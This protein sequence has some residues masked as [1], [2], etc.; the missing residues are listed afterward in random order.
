[1]KAGHAI[2]EIRRFGAAV[3]VTAADPDSL[4]EVS[5]QAPATAG[6]AALHQLALMKL[7]RAIE[8]ARLGAGSR[9]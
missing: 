2:I 5:F 4:V 9:G 6:E 3:K 7:A 1:M 8:R